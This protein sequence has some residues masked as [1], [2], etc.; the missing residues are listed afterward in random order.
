MGDVQAQIPLKAFNHPPRIPHDRLITVTP[1][2]DAATRCRHVRMISRRESDCR[3]RSCDTVKI[4]ANFI[5]PQHM[6]FL[7][8][9]PSNLNHPAKWRPQIIPH[10]PRL[11]GVSCHFLLSLENLLSSVYCGVFNG[12]WNG[13][14]LQHRQLNFNDSRQIEFGWIN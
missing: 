13:H 7:D 8:R 3:P 10:Y 12:T 1:E 14:P 4:T 11:C 9:H 5:K 2:Y 6:C